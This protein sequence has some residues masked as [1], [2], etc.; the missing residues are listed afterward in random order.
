MMR[1]NQISQYGIQQYQKSINKPDEGMKA[2][3]TDKVEIS[4]QAMELQSS[5]AAQAERQARI[6]E[7]KIQIENGTY[8]VNTKA[9]AEGLL[10]FYSKK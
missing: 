4:R 2:T 6:D 5:P 7:I 1:I 10:N 3:Q 8:Q 9:T